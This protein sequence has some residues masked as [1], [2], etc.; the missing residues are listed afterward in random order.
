MGSW[1]L[2]SSNSRWPRGDPLIPLFCLESSRAPISCSAWIFLKGSLSALNVDYP[3]VIHSL[4]ARIHTRFPPFYGNKSKLQVESRQ[5]P[6]TVPATASATLK[7]INH[8]MYPN[9]TECLRM[10]STLPVTTCECER[11]VLWHSKKRLRRRLAWQA[12]EKGR[13]KGNRNRAGGGDGDG[14]GSARFARDQFSSLPSPF[15]RLPR[16]LRLT[17]IALLYIHYNMNMDID[18]DF[19][20]TICRFARLHPRRMELANIVWLTQKAR[21]EHFR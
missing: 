1:Q 14:D 19:D 13:E 3:R 11:N 2:L 12:L 20:E 9:I 7:E 4:Q 21:K 16:R 5:D 17:V 18:I 15:W 8:T 10:F 6:K